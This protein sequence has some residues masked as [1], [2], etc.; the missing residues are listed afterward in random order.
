MLV[1]FE[2]V[3]MPVLKPLLR[4]PSSNEQEQQRVEENLQSQQNEM[5]LVIQKKNLARKLQHFL[6]I[7]Q[8]SYELDWELGVGFR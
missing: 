6:A 2:S 7:P 1:L 3:F 8:M 4:T 5:E